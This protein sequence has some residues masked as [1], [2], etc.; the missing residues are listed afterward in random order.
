M[1]RSSILGARVVE[2]DPPYPLH[3]PVQV[4]F[5]HWRKSRRGHIFARGKCFDGFKLVEGSQDLYQRQVKDVYWFVDDKGREDKI[6]GNAPSIWLENGERWHSCWY[7][8]PDSRASE[9]KLT[10]SDVEKLKIMRANGE[11]P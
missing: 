3:H 10:F 7:C 11:I 1:M 9:G 5:S 8:F 2:K 4:K 6:T